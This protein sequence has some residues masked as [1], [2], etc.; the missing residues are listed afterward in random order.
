M[1]KGKMTWRDFAWYFEGEG[2]LG[3]YR[4]D[5]HRSKYR[6]RVSITSTNKIL[7]KEIREQFPMK[8]NIC[9]SGIKGHGEGNRVLHK[10]A[11]QIRWMSGKPL[12]LL[13]QIVKYLPAYSEKL[14]QIEFALRV[15]NYANEWQMMKM[16]KMKKQTVGERQPHLDFPPMDQKILPFEVIA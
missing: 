4:G 13:E 15:G 16:K 6:L 10:D 12:P 11:W 9:R 3:Y 2:S 14:P 5:D 8:G 1:Y 7:I